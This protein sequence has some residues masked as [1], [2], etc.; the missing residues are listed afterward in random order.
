MHYCCLVITK[1]FPTD[2]VLER[3]LTPFSEDVFYRQPE[4][5]RVYPTIMWGR[6]QIGGRYSGQFKL[7]VNRNDQKYQWGF[8]TKEPRNGRLFRSHRLN[9]IRK[10]SKKT[11]VYR[12][13]D[14]FSNMGFNEGFLYI[15]G[16][17]V[18]DIKNFNDVCCDCCIDKS[19]N[20]FSKEYWNG[21]DF[22]QN[23]NFDQQLAYV[24]ADSRDCY[25]CIIDIC[26]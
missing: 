9:E 22:I 19:G 11:F 13:E 17:L 23:S 1:E 3:V 25:A 12:E 21:N 15:D 6:W 5:S 26:D 18:S 16:G 7:N 4:E 14:Y 8:Y 10:L 24:I 2:E 20:A